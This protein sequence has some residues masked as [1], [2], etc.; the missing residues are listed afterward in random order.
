MS[1]DYAITLSSNGRGVQCWTVHFSRSGQSYMRR[2]YFGSRRSSEEARAAA[3]AWRDQQLR[4][5]APLKAAEFCNKLRTTNTSGVPGVTFYRPQKMPAGIWQ[6]RLHRLHGRPLVKSFSV[7]RYG[8]DGAFAKAVEA[9][10]HM[11]EVFGDEPYLR[12]HP[13][14]EAARAAGHVSPCPAAGQL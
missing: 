1:S 11:L 8:H 6:A 7:K 2:F 9:R 4:D 13:A 10:R 12:A 5:V 14:H 3:E